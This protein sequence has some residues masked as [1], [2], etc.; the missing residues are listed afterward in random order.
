MSECLMDGIVRHSAKQAHG[1]L[2]MN[3]E[4]FQTLIQLRRL[5]KQNLLQHSLELPE[6]CEVDHEGSLIDAPLYLERLAAKRNSFLPIRM[7][8]SKSLSTAVPRT[9]YFLSPSVTAPR[10]IAPLS[11]PS[12]FASRF[13]LFTVPVMFAPS[14]VTVH[15]SVKMP[16]IVLWIVTIQLPTMLAGGA[17]VAA[18]EISELG[19][20]VLS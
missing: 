6:P 11:D 13:L 19:A 9:V 5:G 17:A 14:C 16:S 3:G 4:I 12:S 2:P 1:N 10:K 15:C 7:V 18:S 20:A 8:P